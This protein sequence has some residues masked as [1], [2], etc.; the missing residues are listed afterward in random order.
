MRLTRVAVLGTLSA[1]TLPPFEYEGE[2]VVVTSSYRVCSGTLE[3]FDRA[4][5]RID[6]RLGL[7]AADEPVRIAILDEAEADRLNL[8]DTCKTYRNGVLV[9]VAPHD[10]ESDATHEMGHAR[11]STSDGT[12]PLFSE[13]I[14]VAVAPALCI[15][16]G[17]P[18]T[19]DKLLNVQTSWQLGLHGYYAGGELVAWLLDTHGPARVLDFLDTLTRPEAATRASE[20]QFVRESYRAHF[21]TELDD[22]IFAHTR[23]LEQLTPEQLG[24]VAPRAPMQGDRIHLLADLDCDS[25]RVETDFRYSNRGFVNW[26]LEIPE[27]SVPRRY[28]LL[29]RLPAETELKIALCVCDL[30]VSGQRSVWTEDSNVGANID[31]EPGTYVVR[32]QG[33]LERGLELDIEIEAYDVE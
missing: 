16:N 10:V 23:P 7:D 20:P 32:W 14:A 30:N 15:P 18:P 21:G 6:Q 1:C 24:C 2:H 4:V 17:T 26:T 28:R 27:T 9:V 12:V 13:G 33:P 8:C 11:V 19:L 29:D 22:D 25:H 31:L 5:E 3:S